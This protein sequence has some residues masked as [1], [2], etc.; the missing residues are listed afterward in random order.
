MEAH[1]HAVQLR[2]WTAPMTVARDLQRY[3]LPLHI[4]R[5]SRHISRKRRLGRKLRYA[6]RVGIRRQLKLRG[7]RC[8]DP[9]W[10]DLDEVD[11]RVIDGRVLFQ[12]FDDSSRP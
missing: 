5:E 3:T 2:D 11:R 1:I 6:D 9:P 8:V 12:N 7:V 4:E 10:I